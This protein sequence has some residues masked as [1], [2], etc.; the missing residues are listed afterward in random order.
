MNVAFPL[1]DSH[2]LAE[3]VGHTGATRRLRLTLQPNTVAAKTRAPALSTAMS[4]V[5]CSFVH[6]AGEMRIFSLIAA[7]T[8]GDSDV[9]EV[10]LGE[11]H[12]RDTLLAL[13]SPAGRGRQQHAHPPAQ[14]GLPRQYQDSASTTARC[15]AATR[16]CGAAPRSAPMSTSGSL[17]TRGN[18]AAGQH[19]CSRVIIY[20]QIHEN[21]C[22][23]NMKIIASRTNLSSG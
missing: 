17:W 10:A 5:R 22:E 16:R 21:Y 11:A 1:R 2:E 20:V 13:S 7:A 8:R 9:S 12:Y 3:W 18:D 6:L 4:C 19:S 14:D 23:P 15:A